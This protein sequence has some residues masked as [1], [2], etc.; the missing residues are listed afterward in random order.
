MGPAR[1]QLRSLLLLQLMVLCSST[2]TLGSRGEDPGPA[3]EPISNM[4]LWGTEASGTEPFTHWSQMW[5]CLGPLVLA[6][7][8]DDTSWWQICRGA[9]A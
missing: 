2:V 6:V 1:R 4:Y 9:E 7:A 8:G 3:N 5:L